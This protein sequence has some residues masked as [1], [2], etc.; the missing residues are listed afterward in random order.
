[1][2][3]SVIDVC[4][5]LVLSTLTSFVIS[6]WTTSLCSCFL[7][8]PTSAY[9]YRMCHLILTTCVREIRS[10]GYYSS[11]FTPFSPLTIRRAQYYERYVACSL[12]KKNER[13]RYTCGRNKLCHMALLMVGFCLK[14]NIVYASRI[15]RYSYYH[16]TVFRW[17]R[18]S[19]NNYKSQV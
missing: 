11:H 12:K 1:M 7:K 6:D 17:I 14:L 2:N 10:T 18:Y 5:F 16:S 9:R 3:L 8:T 13:T 4:H 15:Y 19:Y